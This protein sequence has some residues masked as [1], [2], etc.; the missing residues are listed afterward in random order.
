MNEEPANGRL[1]QTRSFSFETVTKGNSDAKL[2]P[3]TSDSPLLPS[4]S[5]VKEKPA[6]DEKIEVESPLGKGNSSI[7]RL[8]IA[9]WK[10]RQSSLLIKALKPGV[11]F[12]QYKVDATFSSI[13]SSVNNI[14][15]GKR[16]VSIA[17]LCH[18]NP[19]TLVFC[20]EKV[21]HHIVQI[22][23]LRISK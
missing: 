19:G 21:C 9:T 3:K 5:S 7:Q 4:Q 1:S 22:H 18:G 17:Y 16:I 2:E 11:E 15:K 20:S 10:I 6:E 23:S 13:L 14:L 12:F 8:V